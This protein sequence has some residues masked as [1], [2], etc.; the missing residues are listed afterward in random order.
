MKGDVVTV[1]FPFSDLSAAKARPALVLI[2]LP[3][4]DVVVA[5]ITSTAADPYAVSLKPVDFE[6]G[7][8]SRDSFIR[9]A[10][11]FTL[12]RGQIGRVVGKVTES[13]RL[14]VVSRLTKLLN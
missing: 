2:E 14:E 8:L 7:S 5:A 11:L 1:L 6:R 9:P 13:K 4:S 10:K 12:E 3:G